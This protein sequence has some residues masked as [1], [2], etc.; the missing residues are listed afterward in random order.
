VGPGGKIR[1][2]DYRKSKPLH[3]KR[4]SY[5]WRDY[6]QLDI[7]KDE[8]WLPQT[9]HFAR[10][11]KTILIAD[12]D[13]QTVNMVGTLLKARGYNIENCP[14][15]KQ[16]LEIAENG[17]IDLVVV[18]ESLT[19]ID[20]IGWIEKL[21]QKTADP[22]V[23][24]LSNKWRDADLYQELT[25]EFGVALVVHRPINKALF[26][27]QVD[28]QLQDRSLAAVEEFEMGMLALKTKFTKMLPKRMEVLQAA[29]QQYVAEPE[30]NDYWKEARRLSHNLKGTSRSCGYELVG[31]VAEKL[32]HTFAAAKESNGNALR[33]M[34]SEI[35]QVFKELKLCVERELTKNVAL[36]KLTD[37]DDVQ[38]NSSVRVLVVTQDTLPQIASLSKALPIRLLITPNA[39]EASRIASNLVLDAVMLDLDVEDR[40]G[41]MNF[42]RELRNLPNNENLPI[43]FMRDPSTPADFGESMHA[44]GGI[45]LDKPSSPEKLAESIHYLVNSREG[46]RPR[47]LAVDDDEDFGSLVSSVLGH[48]GMIV[49]TLNDP[50]S[51]LSFMGEYIPDLILLDVNMPA[52]NGFELCRMLRANQRWR[53]LPIIF[54][55]GEIGL[56][57][58]ISAFDAGGDDYLPK[59]VS[60]VELI[61][62]VKV[63][64][65]RARMLRERADKDILTG[66]HIRRSFI[67]AVNAIHSESKRAGLVFSIAL[68]DVDNFKKVNDTYGHIPGDRVLAHLGKLLRIRFRT[69]DVRGRWGGEEFILAFRHVGKET[70]RGGVERALTELR[71]HTFEGDH[72]EKFSVTFSCGLASF[73]EDGATFPELLAGA[74]KRLYLAKQNGRNQI[75]SSDQG[76]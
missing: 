46:G 72:G 22:K 2:S 34:T 8:N 47:I 69:Q 66:L 63:R 52:L 29:V 65:E 51:I 62:R 64:L 60:P 28:S 53:D 23:I 50:S 37:A 56:E 25:K 42:A 20:G 40:P 36:G 5:H 1:I 19:D 7:L 14:N 10:M 9:E 71:G 35:D 48:E 11:P 4:L 54:L 15:G 16:A 55:T 12:S 57:A 24:F 30:N 70:I 6:A 27:G 32:E 59:P 13:V 31:D 3:T 45:H 21:R 67:E 43:G 74:D 17:S 41:L 68:I 39:S 49:K 75:I 38:D 76:G 61:M 73:P 58:R 44:G 18:G 33:E 26:A